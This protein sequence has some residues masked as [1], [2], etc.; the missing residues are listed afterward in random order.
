MISVFLL[1]VSA[2]PVGTR[3][4]TSTQLGAAGA[5]HPEAGV[6]SECRVVD[7]DFAAGGNF[8]T[9]HEREWVG[10]P[11][12]R[13]ARVVAEVRRRARWEHEVHPQMDRHGIHVGL[14]TPDHAA[15][16]LIGDED[17]PEPL[18]GLA[19]RDGL[20]GHQ[21]ASLDGR[22]A[23]GQPRVEPAVPSGVVRSA[24]HSSIMPIASSPVP[25]LRSGAARM[26]ARPAESIARRRCPGRLSPRAARW[27]RPQGRHCLTRCS[28]SFSSARVPSPVFDT[29]V[30]V[31]AD[32]G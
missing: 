16:L 19:S 9:R 18:D 20:R 25:V 23:D 10:P 24:F 14:R 6:V 4:G 13:F 8:A 31:V 2:L 32:A 17:S 15:Q 28:S 22:R 11:Q 12:R 1:E 3:D 21:A 7:S 30:H 5:L 29:A 26:C 27:S